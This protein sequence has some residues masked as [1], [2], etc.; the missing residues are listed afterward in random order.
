MASHIFEPWKLNPTYY[1]GILGPHARLMGP[2]LK[3]TSDHKIHD[4]LSKR[5]EVRKTSFHLFSQTVLVFFQPTVVLL[6]QDLHGRHVRSHEI[7]LQ[8]RDFVKVVWRQGNVEREA[9]MLI[10]VPEPTGGCIIVGAGKSRDL[11]HNFKPHFW[12]EVEWL[13]FALIIFSFCNRI[14]IIYFRDNSI[15]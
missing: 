12:L 3:S 7:S 9:S 1:L 14:D 15:P 11:L 5:R 8:E 4:R 6:Y 13:K 2:H 10:P